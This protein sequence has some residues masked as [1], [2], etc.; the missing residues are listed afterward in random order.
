MSLSRRDAIRVSGAVLAGVTRSVRRP[1]GD[2]DHLTLSV[3]VNPRGMALPW[4]RPALRGPGRAPPAFGRLPAPVR[5]PTPRGICKWTVLRFRDFA[6]LTGLLS[7]A[8]YGRI[9]SRDRRYVDEEVPT[10]L[11]PQVMLTWLMSDEPIPHEHGAPLRLI[12]P[13]PHG[14]RRPKAVTEIV[15]GTPGGCDAPPRCQRSTRPSFAGPLRMKR[16][17]PIQ[18]PP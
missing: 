16:S 2:Y 7:N 1:H 4:R 8:H 13:V 15:F 11:H 14:A 5:P 6:N 12:V 10:L 9:V 17:A 18:A 3:R